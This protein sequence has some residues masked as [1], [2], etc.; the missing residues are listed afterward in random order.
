MKRNCVFKK[1]YGGEWA[2]RLF[3]EILWVI[4]APVYNMLCY[5]S[6]SI[7]EHSRCIFLVSTI[8]STLSQKLIL[9]VGTSPHIN[10]NNNEI[11][12][13]TSLM[14]PPFHIFIKIHHLPR[15][16]SRTLSNAPL[17]FPPSSKKSR[18]HL[19]PPGNP[20]TI[21]RCSLLR[22]LNN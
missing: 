22:K 4:M 6:T 8:H 19:T 13:T 3:C 1:M 15:E 18:Q 21:V 14:L 9:I 10:Q 12:L 7:P 20:L 2:N 16:L 17:L 5:K 11:T